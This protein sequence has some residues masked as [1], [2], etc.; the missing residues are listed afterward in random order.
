VTYSLLPLVA[1]NPNG[2]SGRVPESETVDL[3]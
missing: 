2:R 3:G 1:Q